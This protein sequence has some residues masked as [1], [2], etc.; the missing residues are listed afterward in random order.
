MSP[1][2]IASV[3]H[4]CWHAVWSRPIRSC[5]RRSFS[6]RSSSDFASA[7]CTLSFSTS[8]R[9][10]FNR[11][12][13]YVHFSITPRSRT[14]TLGLRISLRTGVFLSW[15]WRKLKRRTLYGQLFEQYRVPT[16]RL[17]VISFNPSWL[18]V[19]APTGQT[20]SHGAFWQCWQ[21]IGWKTASGSR[22]GSPR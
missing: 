15:Y 12:T 16:H 8:I 6:C 19:V 18:C 20:T 1:K 7:A 9:A 10:P 22:P 2:T 11:C 17:Y 14:V 13:Q 3:G 5:I 4:D 21:S